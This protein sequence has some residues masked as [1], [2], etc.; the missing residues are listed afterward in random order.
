MHTSEIQTFN[1]YAI[2]VTSLLQRGALLPRP[3]FNDIEPRQRIYYSNHNSHIDF[4]LLWASLPPA[5]RRQTRPVTGAD[6]WLTGRW[7]RFLIQRVFNAILVDRE[8]NTPD[9]QPLQILL[10]ALE[11]RDSMILFP[12]GT[13]NPNEDGLLPFKSGLFH[14]AQ[15]RPD[16]ELIPVWI[17]N[18]NRVMPKGRSLPL[19]L[20]CTVHFGAPIALGENESKHEFLVRAQHSLL[21]LS[22]EED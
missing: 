18:L 1:S 21:A 6:Y 4:L 17:A 11:Q 9:S 22:E 19:P 15:Q 13:R 12:E 5:L 2:C 3:G 8:G 20:L 10:D 16:V 7:R 14:L